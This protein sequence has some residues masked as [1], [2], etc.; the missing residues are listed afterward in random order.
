MVENLARIIKPK[1]VIEESDRLFNEYILQNTGPFSHDDM[2]AYVESHASEALLE[3][4][5]NDTGTELRK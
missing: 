3:Y 5:R 1:W 2:M 4:L